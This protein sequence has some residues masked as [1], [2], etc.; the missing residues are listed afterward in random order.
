MEIDKNPCNVLTCWVMPCIIFEVEKV[1][2][3]IPFYKYLN[4]LILFKNSLNLFTIW[5]LEMS[6]NPFKDLYI[7]CGTPVVPPRCYVN[8]GILSIYILGILAGIL[9]LK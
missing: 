2:D 5:K 9:V 7:P 4:L 1:L 6:L 8:A 3:D